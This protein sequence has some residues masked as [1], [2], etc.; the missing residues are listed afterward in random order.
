MKLEA[1]SLQLPALLFIAVLLLTGCGV[2]AA[3]ARAPALE[4]S[5]HD[6]NGA[7]IRRSGWYPGLIL[8][9][10]PADAG[11]RPVQM[12]VFNSPAEAESTTGQV[13]SEYHQAP[14][15]DALV[16][17][18]QLPPVAERLPETPIVVQ[19]EE[20]IGQ[21]GGTL[22]KAITGQA[23]TD[24]VGSWWL[25]ESLTVH[26]PKGEIIPNVAEG[27]EWSD[28]YT[29]LTLNLRQ[30]IKWS[31]GEPFTA[32]DIMFWWECLLNEELTPSMPTLLTRGGEPGGDHHARRLHGSILVQ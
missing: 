25:A 32:N 2:P 12:E 10:A 28:D 14:E 30:G 19:P 23:Q 11:E 18:G 7:G 1:R 17:S 4:G 8:T 24:E 13:I 15:L 16:A 9:D 22:R 3:P 5:R 26:S 29:Q 31:D 20:A 6:R 27:W 21:Y